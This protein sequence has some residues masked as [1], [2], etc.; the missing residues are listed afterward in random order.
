[1]KRVRCSSKATIILVVLTIII[2]FSM[3]FV[4]NDEKY[5]ANASGGS[6]AVVIEQSTRRVLF[7]QNDKARLPM[8][9]TTKILTALT[10]IETANN[11]DAKFKIPKQAV[12]IEGSS[13]YLVEGEELSLREL[14]YGLMLRSGNDSAVALSLAVCDTTENF[15]SLMNK[16]ALECGAKN[17]NFTNP[18]G[19]HNEN[20]Y[21]TAYDLALITARA[22]E[23]DVFK[24]IVSTK[25]IKISGEIPR[26]LFNKNK[27][28]RL[29]D[30]ANGVKTGFTKKSGRCL[31]S[32]AER[33]GMQLIS[34]VLNHGDMW[35]DSMSMLNS[36]FSRYKM[37]KIVDNDN[38]STLNV[39]K[40][41]YPRVMINSD[42]DF[43]FPLTDDEY[44]S[45]KIDVN[46][47]DSISA[48]V[49]NGQYVGDIKIYI[50]NYLIFCQ[51]FYT[52]H[53]VDKVTGIRHNKYKQWQLKE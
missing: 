28:L 11:L 32:A 43:M 39:I 44:K 2:N 52:M 13:I 10:V 34:V 30:G 33:G 23:H 27:M 16:K 38:I 19:L 31:V 45:L 20:H 40:G 48:P 15:V 26:V 25:E 53:S 7:S 4:N 5:V 12:G 35:N 46:L 21:T 22:F 6:G 24:E 3:F 41:K 17:S 50:G 36:A 42:R 37:R 1:K 18:H 14:L 9:S 47:P 51:K 49:E 29:F 8:A